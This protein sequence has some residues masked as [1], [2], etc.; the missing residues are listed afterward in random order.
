MTDVGAPVPSG[1]GPVKA[2]YGAG[3]G[4][5]SPAQRAVCHL[6]EGERLLYV[7]PT[8]LDPLL[9]PRLPRRLRVGRAARLRW[10]APLTCLLSTVLRLGD[11]WLGWDLWTLGPTVWEYFF[12]WCRRPYRMVRRAV[13]GG[14]WGG[15]YES[16]AG[17]FVVAVR[18]APPWRHGEHD[19]LLLA[20]T[21]HRLLALPW[22]APSAGE[23]E[24]ISAQF[25]Q[26]AF[27]NRRE[28][29]PAGRRL[30]VALEFRDGSWVG[31]VVKSEQEAKA[32][33]AAWG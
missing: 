27:R 3:R 6:V 24:E 31:L 11:Y 32:L 2:A 8:E 25:P 30:R 18:N 14:V 23:Q 13:R 10:W 19:R 9:P 12:D 1:T 29:L 15:G 20:V 17:R 5:L 26:G 33:T 16:E 7:C 28:P 22:K 4:H 21:S